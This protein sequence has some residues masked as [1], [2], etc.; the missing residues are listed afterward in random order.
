MIYLY[1]KTHNVTG[2]KY[3]GK[4]VSAD[5]HSYPGSGTRWKRHIKKHGNDVT[6]E[7]LL[8]SSD[9]EELKETGLFFSKLWNVVEDVNWANIVPESGD[10]GQTW[11]STNIHLHPAKKNSLNGTHSWIGGQIQSQNNKKR[12]SEGTHHLL[13]GMQHK[14]RVSEGTHHLLGGAQQRKMVEEGV[15]GML[16]KVTCIDKHGIR[17]CV[18]KDVYY[19]QVGPQTDWEYVHIG[20]KEG[21]SRK[22]V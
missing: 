15:H 6:T 13:G 3:L 1:V 16:G 4:T 22:L 2:L 17:S 18:D 14:K 21:K 5:P 7:I 9:K 10:G 20:T 11:N 19:N 12:V 8:A